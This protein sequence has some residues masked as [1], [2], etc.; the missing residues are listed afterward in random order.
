MKQT[1]LIADGDAEL[2]DRQR[3]FL[4]ERGYEVE[5]ASDGLECLENLR[6]VT[7]DVLVLDQELHWGGGDGVLAWLRELGVR[8]EVAVVLTAT[9]GFSP[10]AAEDNEPPVVKF[11]PKPFGLAALLE[12]VQAAV[13]EKGREPFINRSRAVPRADHEVVSIVDD[14][15]LQPLLVAQLLPAQDEPAHIQI[16]QKR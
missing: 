12:S 14:M 3:Q 2:S 7:P 4:T 11:L 6:R 9:A 5:T 15:S 8:P 16:R 13:G 1:V 10:H